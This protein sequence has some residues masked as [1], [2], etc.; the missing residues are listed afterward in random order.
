M[1]NLLL[2]LREVNPFLEKH[3]ARWTLAEYAHQIVARRLMMF[4]A[5]LMNPGFGH[6]SQRC[7]KRHGDKLRTAGMAP[8]DKASKQDTC[9]LQAVGA[10]PDS[11]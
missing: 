10:L 8:P 9:N 5:T 11:S 4:G 3:L 6:H 7:V 1:F 2:L